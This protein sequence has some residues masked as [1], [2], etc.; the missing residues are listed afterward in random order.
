MNCAPTSL[1]NIISSMNTESCQ[2][3]MNLLH[4][5]MFVDTQNQLHPS[6]SPPGYHQSSYHCNSNNGAHLSTNRSAQ[7]NMLQMLNEYVP[8]TARTTHTVTRCANI[9][10]CARMKRILKLGVFYS[11]YGVQNTTLITHFMSASS[12]FKDL[13]TDYH[14]S[15]Q[16]HSN[17]ADKQTIAE[18]SRDYESIFDFICNFRHKNGGTSHFNVDL[19]Y[20]NFLFYNDKMGTIYEGMHKEPINSTNRINASLHPPSIPSIAMPRTLK[21]EPLLVQPATQ[22]LQLMKAPH[23]N[24]P[25]PLQ[26][27]DSIERKRR[28][29]S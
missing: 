14:H 10:K 23:R 28:S 25:P 24:V 7:E 13:G 12:E 27:V 4:Q 19:S 16:Y 18:M 21:N 1:V 8:I 5:S 3:L 29:K 9:T 26:L 15:V 17:T 11:K 2:K 20:A 22:H 6:I